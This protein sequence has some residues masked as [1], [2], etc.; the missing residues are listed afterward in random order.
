MV[1]SGPAMYPTS[2]APWAN[3]TQMAEKTWRTPNTLSVF[4]SK[5]SALSCIAWTCGSKSLIHSFEM[6]KFPLASFSS[7]L[8]RSSPLWLKKSLTPL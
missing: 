7:V 2:P 3:I 4:E 5:T 6:I 1:A 8:P